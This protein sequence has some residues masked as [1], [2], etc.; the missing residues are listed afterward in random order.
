MHFPIAGVTN[1]VKG[2]QLNN[3]VGRQ[4]KVVMDVLIQPRNGFFFQR[5]TSHN[6]GLGARH[7]QKTGMQN[8]YPDSHDRQRQSQSHLGLKLLVTWIP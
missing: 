4:L 2:R 7:E 6:I 8:H 1:E 5:Q 3:S